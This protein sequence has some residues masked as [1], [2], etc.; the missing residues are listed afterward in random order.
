MARLGAAQVGLG[1]VLF[2]AHYAHQP[3]H[4]FAIHF[5][6]EG[7]F[8]AAEKRPQQV[9]LVDLSHHSQV[10]RTLGKRCV[11]IGR[12]RQCQQFALPLDAQAP[13]FRVDPFAAF[14]NR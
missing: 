5:Q 14:F 13:M 7:D 10:L 6:L 8:P 12:A 9:Q 1:V 4:P 3:L 2:Y 11:V